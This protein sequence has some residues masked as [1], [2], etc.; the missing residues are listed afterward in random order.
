MILRPDRRIGTAIGAAIVFVAL[1]G[2]FVLVWR[3]WQQAVGLATFTGVLGAALLLTLGAVFAYW[4]VACWT[5]RYLLSKN[6]LIIRW[7]GNELSIPLHDVVS[8]PP[9][10]SV[11]PPHAVRPQ[12]VRWPGYHVGQATVEGLEGGNPV[13]FFTAYT[14]PSELVYVRTSGAVYALSAPDAAGFVTALEERRKEAVPEGLMT[15]T[16]RWVLADLAFWHDRWLTALALL[17]LAVNLALFAYVTYWMP[18][19]PSLIQMHFT[20][21][22]IADI[23]SPKTDLLA[24]PA[25]GL[26][27]LLLNTLMSVV[28]HRREALVAHV[29]TAAALVVQ[30]ALWESTRFLVS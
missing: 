21:L 3:V 27:V 17:A 23:V 5:L 15:R 25:A 16:H 7:G 20:H 9:G 24:L 1:F 10:S 30:L 18:A 19:L 4:T 6:R 26:G 22:G 2:A 12:G 8:V 29:L 28:F 14:A 11:S 13:L